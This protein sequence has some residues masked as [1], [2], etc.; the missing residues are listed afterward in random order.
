MLQSAIF[1]GKV[2][3]DDQVFQFWHGPG[4]DLADSGRFRVPEHVY[5]LVA[6]R[7]YGTHPVHAVRVTGKPKKSIEMKKQVYV[8]PWA[9][10]ASAPR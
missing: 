4:L 6:R 5:D 10:I 2:Q 9:G 7:R 8:R 3:S 1:V